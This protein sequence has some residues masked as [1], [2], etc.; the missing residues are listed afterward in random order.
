MFVLGGAAVCR[1]HSPRSS[2]PPPFQFADLS[3]HFLDIDH[4]LAGPGMPE[5]RH[6][7]SIGQTYCTPRHTR[8]STK[9]HRAG[10]AK[11]LAASGLRPSYGG[12]SCPSLPPLPALLHCYS[13]TDRRQ[14]HADGHVRAHNPSGGGLARLFPL[15]IRRDRR[16][17]Q[18]G[19]IAGPQE[20]QRVPRGA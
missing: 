2:P 19:P 11:G 20:G 6:R 12:L 5:I 1:L 10:L 18:E 3:R 7:K 9:F 4:R 16:G 17:P 8:T 13:P 15:R 14:R